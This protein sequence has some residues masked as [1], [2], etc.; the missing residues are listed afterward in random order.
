MATNFNPQVLKYLFPTGT[1]NV[2]SLFKISI[3]LMKRM[4]KAGEGGKLLKH[5]FKVCLFKLLMLS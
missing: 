1:Q 5:G 3:K 4:L 2:F